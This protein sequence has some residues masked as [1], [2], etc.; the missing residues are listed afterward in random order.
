MTLAFHYLFPPITIGLGVM[1]VCMEGTFLLT[2]RAVF[3]QLTRFF[4]KL[5]GL[6]FAIGVVTGIPMEFQF[7]TNWAQYSRFVGDVFGSALAA[8]GIFAFFLESGFLGLLLFGWDRVRPR[9]HFFATIMVALGS[10]FS[11]IWIIVANSWMQTPAGFKIVGTGIEARAI[12]TDFFQ[13]VFNPSFLNRLF[14]TL[15]GAWQAGAFFVMSV[16]AWY[17][18]KNR[19]LEFARAG[20]RLGLIV[21]ALAATAS[22]ILGDFSARQVAYTQ[23][24]KLAAME[25]VYPPSAPAGLHMF[26][27][28]DE[29]SQ[30]VYGPE[31]PGML[32]WLVYFDTHKPVTGLN[33]FKPEDRPPVNRVFQA[34]HFM[35]AIG[36]ASFGLTALGLIWWG[37]GKLWTARWLLW[38]FVFGIIFILVANEAGWMTAEWGRQPWIV[39]GVMRTNQG[40]SATVPTGQVWATITLFAIVYSLLLVLYLFL[41][42]EKIQNGPEVEHVSVPLQGEPHP[43]ETAATGPDGLPVN[44]GQTGPVFTGSRRADQ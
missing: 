9:T 17:L 26:G 25:G 28:V 21:A 13:V 42:N 22:I 32:S 37:R 11:A 19:S 20:M 40:V 1:L 6:N 41:L 12:T 4:V 15:A 5:F 16:C 8:E 38:P 14:H 35:V 33:A 3:E 23:P 34:F 31:M 24:A 18:L 7:G 2:R 29:A 10:H 36:F 43:W 39:Y 30:T 27:W 44:P